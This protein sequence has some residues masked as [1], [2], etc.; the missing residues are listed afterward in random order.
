MTG[1]A[2]QRR[3]VDGNFILQLDDP[4]RLDLA[5][6][7]NK[8]EGFTGIDVAK[9]EGVD[10]TCDLSKTPWRLTDVNATFYDRLEHR[11][12]DDSVDEVYCSH[13]FEHLDGIERIGFMNELYRVLKPHHQ[14]VI[15]VP[16]GLSIRAVQDPTHKWPPVVE[17]SFL[18]FFEKWRVAN[19]LSHYPIHCNFWFS[20]DYF[21]PETWKLRNEESRNFALKHYNNVVEDLHVYLTK[22]D[23]GEEEQP[24]VAATVV[25][26]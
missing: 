18:Y 6:G 14:A 11:L 12:A 24:L 7:Q 23:P 21:Y 25:S 9:C 8:Q 15:I 22:L 17:T 4:V 3:M 5:C 1:Q 26:K 19:G 2:A 10:F 13:F 20:F 16:Y